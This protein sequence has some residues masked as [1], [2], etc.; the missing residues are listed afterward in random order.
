MFE[1]AI[2]I[3]HIVV[4]ELIVSLIVDSIASISDSDLDILNRIVSPRIQNADTARSVS[5]GFAIWYVH[6]KANIPDTDNVNV[7]W[8]SIP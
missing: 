6:L 2:N 7:V 3:L 4:S 5:S 8:N 1:V